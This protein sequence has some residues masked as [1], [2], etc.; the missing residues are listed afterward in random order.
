MAKIQ[1]FYEI[2][3][4]KLM[5]G[6]YATGTTR[7][8]H[9][10]WG[11]NFPTVSLN[12]EREVQD[13]YASYDE[14][15]N[16]DFSIE[17]MTNMTGSLM[18]DTISP[19]NMAK[20]FGD[21]SVSTVTQAAVTGH[22]ETVTIEKQ[23]I[24]IKVGVT[25][26]NPAGYRNL[27]NLVITKDAGAVTLVA[28]VDYELDDN[29][30]I[31]I[32]EGGAIE[33]GDTIEITTDI[34][35]GTFNRIIS[36]TASFRGAFQFITKNKAGRNKVYYAPCAVIRPSGD[37]TLVTESE[38]AQLSFTISFEKLIGKP[39]MFVDDKPFNGQ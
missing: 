9:F 32:L 25:D 18:T 12:I 38:F 14:D 21:G 26:D 15:R 11:G 28:Y 3:R 39:L 7:P 13:H 2:Q 20:W 10:E 23:G 4:G 37:F 33:A 35:A 31:E 24:H 29:G 19:Q 5:L 27:E 30:L 22:T 6:E 16:K 17:T 1:D 8:K 36:K 34:A